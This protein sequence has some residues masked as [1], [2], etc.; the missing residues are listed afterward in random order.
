MLADFID[1]KGDVFRRIAIAQLA[2]RLH[3]WLLV[4]T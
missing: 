3:S 4:H 2:P 1:G